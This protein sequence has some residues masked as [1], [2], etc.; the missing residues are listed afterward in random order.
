MQTAA[1]DSLWL[2]PLCSTAYKPRRVDAGSGLNTN[3]KSFCCL[4]AERCVMCD[5]ICDVM[6]DVWCGM[7]SWRAVPKSPCA[8]AVRMSWTLH[9]VLLRAGC[10]VSVTS[11]ERE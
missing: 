1:T 5:V 9:S 10:L 3:N 8:M 6:C 7:C 2:M 4:S 11:Y